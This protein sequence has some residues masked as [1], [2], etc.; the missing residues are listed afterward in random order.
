MQIE[1]RRTGKV[2]FDGEF[3]TLRGADLSGA[4]LSGANLS[5]AYMRQAD[6]SGADL[7]EAIGNLREVF[8]LNLELWPIVFT[9]DVLAIGCQ[10]HPIEAWRSFSD[11]DIRAMSRQALYF[12]K[13][14]KNH[15]FLTIELCVGNNLP[16]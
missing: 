8:N 6:L 3:G 14:W 15:I 16:L 13:K 11:D 4:D 5:G 7:Q 2:I 10:Q 1:H 9:K 12:W